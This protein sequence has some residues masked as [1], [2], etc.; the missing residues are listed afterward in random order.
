[1][2]VP[3]CIWISFFGQAPQHLH[4]FGK[5]VPEPGRSFTDLSLKY[6]LAFDA[7]LD[8]FESFHTSC[9]RVCEQP[10]IYWFHKVVAGPHAKCFDNIGSTDTGKNNDLGNW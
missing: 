6:D 10:D 3:G 5:G 1:M 9:D 4:G 2:L 8:E 7:L